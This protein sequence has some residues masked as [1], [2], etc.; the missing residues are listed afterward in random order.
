MCGIV[1]YVGAR[2]AAPVVLEGLRKLEYRGYDSAGVAT[3]GSGLHVS[4]GAGRIGDVEKKY[5]LSRLPGKTG[6]AHTR[7]A[8]HGGVTDE[9]AHPHTDCTGS[10]AIVHNGI[11]ENFQELRREL[12]RKGHKFKTQCDPEVFAHLVEEGI[13]RRLALEEAVFKASQRIQG[14]YAVLAISA[15]SPGKI[16]VA[17]KD[18]PIVI[19]LAA[20]ETF[21]A[22]DPIPLVGKAESVVFLDD[23]EGALLTR[24]GAEFYDLKTMQKIAKKPQK[25]EMGYEAA[26]KGSHEHYYLKEILEEPE[27]LRRALRQ[28]EAHVHSIA[29]DILRAQRAMIIACGTA[30][31]ASLIGRYVLSKVGGKFCEVTLASEFGYFSDSIGKESLVLGVSQSGET[32]DLLQ[33]LKRVKANGAKIYSIVNVVGSSLARESEKTFYI[34]AGP[35]IAVASTKAFVNQVAAFSMLAYSMQN[36]YASIVGK[37][38]E[39]ADLSEKTLSENVALAKALAKEL[40]DKQHIYLI[41]RGINF[42]VATEGALK[43]KELS[44]IHAEGMPG[45]ELKHGTLALIEKGTPV[46]VLA[47]KDYTYNEI[48]SNAMEAKARGARIIGLSDEPNEIFDEWFK[49]PKVE[50]IF[51]H[52]VEI[53]PIQLLSYYLT[54]ELGRDPD[55]PRNLAKSCTVK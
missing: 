14:E 4:K 48:I 27:A 17:R 37:L 11:I 46:I 43:I 19:G 1:G 23:F 41:G 35:E 16:A 33:P 53:L 6:V 10:V 47:P 28:D 30:R 39:V 24:D 5:S 51:Y 32:M 18:S 36:Q 12:E 21:A 50:E 52:L 49:I 20:G 40:K 15:D 34:N 54:L 45:G 38:K 42:A 8:T 13:S 7:W 22:S 55:K 26:S 9:N 31:H 29:L 3:V 25:L 2:N 44:Y